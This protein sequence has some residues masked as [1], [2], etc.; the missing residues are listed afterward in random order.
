[1]I[2]F[3]DNLAK[4]TRVMSSIKLMRRT[5]AYQQIIA[6]GKEAVPDLLDALSHHPRGGRPC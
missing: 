3:L 6:Q 2:E 4:Q 1:M 5:E